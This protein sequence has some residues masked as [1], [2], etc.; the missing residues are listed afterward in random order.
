MAL[1][2]KTLIPLQPEAE[3]EL[4]SKLVR[5]REKS[6]FFY[7]CFFFLTIRRN[8]I[9]LFNGAVPAPS[10]MH[11]ASANVGNVIE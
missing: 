5:V 2:K 8:C 9:R 6:R 3:K 10:N 1:F 4:D 7:K 11:S